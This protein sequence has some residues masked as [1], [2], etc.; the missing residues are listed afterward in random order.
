MVE[1]TIVKVMKTRRRLDHNSL[2]TEATKILS[3]KFAP[4]PL[5][6]KKRIESLIEREYM[7]RDN[8]DRR[9]YKYIA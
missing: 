3:Q 8:E 2:I 4:D 7:E 1:A 5:M 9:Y 6:I